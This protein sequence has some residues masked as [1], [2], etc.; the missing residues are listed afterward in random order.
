MNPLLA[1]VAQQR[2]FNR[3]MVGLVTAGFLV[4]VLI[5][6]MAGKA[7]VLAHR[8]RGWLDISVEG[9]GCQET[10]RFDGKAT[11][12]FVNCPRTRRVL[13]FHSGKLLTGFD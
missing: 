9:P 8:T 13:C 11:F 10:R 7:A 3:L 1:L 5:G 2:F 4:L 12:A 6:G